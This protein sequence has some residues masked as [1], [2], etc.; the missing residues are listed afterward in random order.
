MHFVSVYWLCMFS[1]FL[2]TAPRL[3]DDPIASV[4]FVPTAAAA[5]TESNLLCRHS[6]RV[7]QRGSRSVRRNAYRGGRGRWS[8]YNAAKNFQCVC[9]SMRA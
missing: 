2:V 9:A 6:G 7:V 5:A 8:H 3:V 1:V 4:C